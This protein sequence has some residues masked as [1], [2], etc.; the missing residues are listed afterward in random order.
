MAASYNL[1][2]YILFH[3]IDNYD[4]CKGF[5]V[6]YFLHYTLD[7]TSNIRILLENSIRDVRM[8]INQQT[9]LDKLFDDIQ[10]PRLGACL[11]ICHLQASENIFKRQISL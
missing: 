7:R 3:I 2:I 8:N 5:G 9:S 11:D 4:K 10:H 6:L 1:E